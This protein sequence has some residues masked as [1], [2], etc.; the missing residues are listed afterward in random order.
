M[1]LFLLQNQK[2][3]NWLQKHQPQK[4]GILLKSQEV[5]GHRATN[6]SQIFEQVIPRLL[7]ENKT[8]EIDYQVDRSLKKRIETLKKK[9]CTE[10][11]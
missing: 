11:I 9:G 6:F 4:V 10:I 5:D 3:Q 1:N 2:Y 8:W 7:I